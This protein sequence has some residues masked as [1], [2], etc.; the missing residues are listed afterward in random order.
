MTGSRF[1]E[2]QNY[3]IH[4]HKK[5]KY[6]NQ[7]SDDI[8]GSK[9]KI[10]IGDVELKGELEDTECAQVIE[11]MLP[12]EKNFQTWGDEIYFPIALEMEL[13][14]TARSE[15]DIGTLGYW[16]PGK[17]VALFFGETPDSTGKKP[18]AASDIN[19][20]GMVQEASKLSSVKDEDTIKI[21]R[22]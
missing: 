19:V 9:I 11:E 5:L 22:L 1:T 14:E 15:V 12:L 13:D 2:A 4:D 20:I 21:E 6:R 7:L 8:M 17:A 16:P 3:K 10:S 18:V